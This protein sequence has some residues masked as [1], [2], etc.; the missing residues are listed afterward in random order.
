M[1]NDDRRPPVWV[2]HVDLRTPDLD[3]TESFFKDVGLRPIFRGDE[4]AV[5]EFR[6]GT[7]L[8]V[9]ADADAAPTDADF[10]LMVEDV[11]AAWETYKTKGWDVTEMSRGKIHDSFHVTEPGGNRLVVN[12]THVPDHDA[13]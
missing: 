13:V 9:I 8:V 10:D 12:S 5:L 6:G 3:A 2:G 1:A 7:H 4:V 11:D